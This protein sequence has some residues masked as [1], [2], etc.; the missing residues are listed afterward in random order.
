M[1]FLKEVFAGRKKLIQYNDLKQV[2]VPRLKEFCADKIYQMA[3]GDER[4][5]QN[6]PDP[7]KSKVRP[8]NK[9][10]LFNV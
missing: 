10:F 1:S 5:F 8:V 9:T 4:V 3:M 6:L 2:N 7:I